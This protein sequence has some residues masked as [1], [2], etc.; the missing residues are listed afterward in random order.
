M[1][2]TEAQQVGDILKAMMESDGNED[3]FNRQKVCYL[4]S[5]VTGPIV[6]RATTRRY[7]DKDIMHVYIDSGPIKS[8]LAFIKC[9]L[10]EKLNEAAGKKVIKNLIIH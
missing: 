6:N 9:Q 4:W 7:I 3:D 2:Q 10:V 1:K 8:E 5:Y